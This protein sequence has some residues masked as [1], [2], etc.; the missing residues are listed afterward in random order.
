MRA[1]KLMAA[2][3]VVGGLVTTAG[4][5]GPAQD[6]APSSGVR[7]P[8]HGTA[9][10]SPADPGAVFEERNEALLASVQA[11]DAGTAASFYTSDAL[12]LPPDGSVIRGRDGIRGYWAAGQGFDSVATER[13]AVAAVDRLASHTAHYTIWSTAADGTIQATRGVFLIVWARGEDGAWRIQADM[14]N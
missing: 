14:W 5:N 6:T 11:G 8:D 3:L 7:A 1:P 4:C 13:V 10:G 12:L 2:A 9:A